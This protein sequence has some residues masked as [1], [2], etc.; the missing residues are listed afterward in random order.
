M[1][2][3]KVCAKTNFFKV[4]KTAL[5]FR[6]FFSF[7]FSFFFF[8]STQPSTNNNSLD[9]SHMK[10]DDNYPTVPFGVFLLCGNDFHGFHV[11]FNDVARGGIRLVFSRDR[12]AF[13][14]NEV[15]M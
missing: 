15:F 7:S 9:L 13:S 6:F 3:N 2:I 1:S 10:K 12:P 5:S 14:R 8:P 11:R 4:P